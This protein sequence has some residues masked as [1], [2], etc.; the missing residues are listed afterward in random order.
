MDGIRS[1]NYRMTATVTRANRTE[2]GAENE[3]MHVLHRD[4]LGKKHVHL[5]P[6]AEAAAGAE[7]TRFAQD[8]WRMPN[9]DGYFDRSHLASLRLHQHEAQHG[10][11]T[12]PAGGILEILSIP[13]MPDQVMGFHIFVVYDP[14][15]DADQGRF[16]GYTIW[17]LE[18]GQ[19]AFGQA[20]AV[21]MAFDIFPP[22]REHRYRKVLFTNHDIYNISRRILYQHK[23]RQF[24]VD[25]RTQISQTRTGS[26]LK[27]A[28]YYLKRGYYPPDQKPLADACLVRLTRNQAVSPRTIR[29]LIRLSQAPYWVYP[30]EKY[31]KRTSLAQPAPTPSASRKR[32]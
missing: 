31:L 32:T 28:I 26:S 10:F 6:L 22:Y 3:R 30:V 18:R 16:I 17:S 15:D 11:A 21:R 1:Q 29:R 8:L 12:L 23:P 4:I 5:Y 2:L 14:R 13:T 19:A 25:A 9:M 7:L 24:L 20:E 27:R